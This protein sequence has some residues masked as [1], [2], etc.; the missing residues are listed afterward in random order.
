MLWGN[1]INIVVVQPVI[2]L[3]FWMLPLVFH[4]L[5]LLKQ[6]NAYTPTIFDLSV[7][8]SLTRFIERVHTNDRTRKDPNLQ[9]AKVNS[10]LLVPYVALSVRAYNR[11]MDSKI[12]FM[13]PKYF[14]WEGQDWH[15][16]P[17]TKEFYR[18][19]LASK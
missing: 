1:I 4:S 14:L 2:T 5:C 16:V 15:I 7:E 3:F 8:K 10:S 18:I 12:F 6:S 17:S 9:P 13:I 11:E 19:I